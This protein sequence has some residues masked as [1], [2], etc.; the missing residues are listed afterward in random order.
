M[1]KEKYFA[2]EQYEVLQETYTEV[3]A[4]LLDRIATKCAPAL[5]ASA[6]VT[7]PSQLVTTRSSLPK[8]VLSRF[9]GEQVEWETFRERFTAMVRNDTTLSSVLKLEH[10]ISC[11]DGEA[12]RRVESLQLIG[13][14]FQ[15]AWETLTKRYDNQRVKLSA[16]MRR[17]LNLPSATSRSATE[18]TL[19]LDGVAVANC[20]FTRLGR[21]VQHCD[22]WLV[23]IVTSRLDQSIREDWEKTLEG[24]ADLPTY[25]DLPTFLKNRARILDAA[26]GNG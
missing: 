21:P 25:N 11:L 5:P 23:N 9:S 12:A 7:N 17:L 4:T 19:R 13:S 20:A 8:L 15:V 10:L 26:S 16:H 2:E 6:V 3:K 14:N 22:D 1:A 24:N 18:I